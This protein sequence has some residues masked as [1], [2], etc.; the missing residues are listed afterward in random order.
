MGGILDLFVNASFVSYKTHY[1]QKRIK[2]DPEFIKYQIIQIPNFDLS[3]PLY[4]SQIFDYENQTYN[5]AFGQNNENGYGL[6][7][8]HDL[9][10]RKCSRNFY[11]FICVHH[12]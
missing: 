7:L 3:K 6:L 5:L 8:L 11:L 2:F 12:K 10:Q 9:N 4:E 1:Y